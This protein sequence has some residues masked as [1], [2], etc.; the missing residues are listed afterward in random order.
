[1][2]LVD[3]RLNAL[4]LVRKPTLKDKAPLDWGFR[5][6]I[7][8]FYYSETRLAA[9]EAPFTTPKLILLATEVPAVLRSSF[10]LAHYFGEMFP[11]NRGSPAAC[12]C[13]ESGPGGKIRP[14]EGRRA[15]GG[16]LR[17]AKSLVD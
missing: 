17:F 6:Q 9:N 15:R 7:S 1:M 14:T 3:L 8:R 4:Y 11:R 12:L 16:C 10:A 2:R 13:R 5:G